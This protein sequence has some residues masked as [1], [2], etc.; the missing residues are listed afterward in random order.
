M[1]SSYRL[2]IEGHTD[3]T[4]SK[5]KNKILSEQRANS[6]AAYLIKY[7]IPASAL[8]TIGYGDEK[9][10]ADNN[11]TKGRNANRRTEMHFEP[12]SPK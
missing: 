2:H 7:G 12:V 3:N 6:V 11:L 1:Y 4:G 5:E 9:P 8:T 10:I